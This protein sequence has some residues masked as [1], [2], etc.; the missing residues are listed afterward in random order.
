MTSLRLCAS[1]REFPSR[2]F[3]MR[4]FNLSIL[5]FLVASAT[6]SVR[7]DELAALA[8]FVNDQTIAVMRVDLKQF[9]F[10]AVIKQWL[11]PM[12]TTDLERTIL[13]VVVR[14][15]QQWTQ[16]IK[17]DD[18]D[19]FY[20]VATLAYLPDPAKPTQFGDDWRAGFVSYSLFVVVP[21]AR[22]K[23]IDDLHNTIQAHAK[24]AW[25]GGNASVYPDCRRIHDAAV[26][27]MGTI[28]DQLAAIQPTTRPEFEKALVAAGGQPVCLAAAPPPIFTRAAE[29]I[30]REPL[31]A[32]INRW[33]SSSAAVY[34]GL[35]WAW[36]R[37][38]KNSTPR[39]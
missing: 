9:D 37:T 34:V 18:L 35:A 16:R 25:P 8:P 3:L 17:A 36:N 1:V 28:L 12:C 26:I 2:I 27:G 10:P 30:L 14:Q 33:E 24:L 31:P 6:I 20:V 7:A 15:L 39:S 23:A 32:Q 11:E 21:G 13:D 38:W 4:Q 5:A 29:E 19:H 22:N